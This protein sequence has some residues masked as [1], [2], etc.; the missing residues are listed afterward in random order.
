MTFLLSTM[1]LDNHSHKATKDNTDTGPDTIYLSSLTSFSK[2]VLD[3]LP[4]GSEP[5]ARDIIGIITKT[6][7]SCDKYWPDCA[8]PISLRPGKRRTDVFSGKRLTWV[9]GTFSWSGWL[10]LSSLLLATTGALYILFG[11]DGYF[12]QMQLKATHTTH[13]TSS[14]TNRQTDNK[15]KKQTNRNVQQTNKKNTTS[16]MSKCNLIRLLQQFSHVGAYPHPQTSSFNQI[17]IL[18][19]WNFSFSLF[20]W[21][22]FLRI[23]HFLYFMETCSNKYHILFVQ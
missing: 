18:I 22:T 20:N 16:A 11:H 15:K 4:T 12:C 1:Y 21:N 9:N 2:K 7:F 13:T 5:L 14:Q 17:S 6:T 23:S 10:P 8:M 19:F 3:C